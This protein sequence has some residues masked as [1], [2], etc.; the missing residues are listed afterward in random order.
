MRFDLNLTKEYGSI[1]LNKEYMVLNRIILI[2]PV[3][4]GTGRSLLMIDLVAE[5][6]GKSL[7]IL[8]VFSIGKCGQNQLPCRCPDRHEIYYSSMQM[9]TEIIPPLLNCCFSTVF[10]CFGQ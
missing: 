5:L 10:N 7:V 1:I 9:E 3:A 2:A 4:K 6:D 8:G